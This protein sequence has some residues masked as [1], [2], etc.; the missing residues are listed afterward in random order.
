M[1]KKLTSLQRLYC[2]LDLQSVPMYIQLL[3]QGCIKGK[4]WCSQWQMGCWADTCSELELYHPKE[5]CINWNKKKDKEN[6]RG[7]N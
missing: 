2:E 3:K 7:T 6:D 5:K 1:N 4:R